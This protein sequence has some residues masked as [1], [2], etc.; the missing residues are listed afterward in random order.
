MTRSA[1]A[2]DYAAPITTCGYSPG[3]MVITVV[4]GTVL[5]VVVLIIGLRKF[6]DDMPLA[7]THSAAIAA[8]CHATKGDEDCALK[9]VKWGVVSEDGNCGHCSFSAGSVEPLVEGRVYR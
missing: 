1:D 2:G 9:P 3:A 4:V 5:A 6:P 7:G 8:A